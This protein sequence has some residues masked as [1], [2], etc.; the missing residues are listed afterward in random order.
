MKTGAWGP[1]WG[2]AQG[3]RS[4]EDLVGT[5]ALLLGAVIL[6]VTCTPHIPIRTTASTSKD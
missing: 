5:L 2:E 6:C 3:L 4:L 1:A